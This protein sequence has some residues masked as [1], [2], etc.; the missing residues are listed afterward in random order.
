M[1]EESKKRWK[2]GLTVGIALY[3]LLFLFLIL[4]ANGKALSH[5]LG[6]VLMLFRPILLG[7]GLSY[8]CNPFFKF[9]ERKCFRHLRPV[10]LR[11]ALSL[12]LAYL[13]ILLFLAV[14][15]M[16]IL[17]NLAES[18]KIL[19]T[20]WDSYMQKATSVFNGLIEQVNKFMERFTGEPLLLKQI[21]PNEP[22]PEN[23]QTNGLLQ[24]LGELLV[25][26]DI[27]GVIEVISGA[28]SLLTDIIFAFFISIYLLGTK[29]KRYAQVM[30]LRYAL[31]NNTW[32][33]NITKFLTVV[34]EAFGSYLIGKL[35]ESFLMGL[36]L[37]C[38][39]SLFGIPYALLAAVFIAITNIIPIIGAYIGAVPTAFI[40]LLA[41]PLKVIPFVAVFLILQQINANIISPKILGERTGISALS[42]LIG[43]CIMGSVFGLAG[44][45][46]GVPLFAALLYM[47][48]DLLS[49]KL[50]QKGLPVGVANYYPAGSIVNPAVD[51]TVH[52]NRIVFS[53]EH[54]HLCVLQKQANAQPISRYQRT[55]DRIYR[56]ARRKNWIAELSDETATA[57][58][59]ECIRKDAAEHAEALFEERTSRATEK[60]DAQP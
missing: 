54:T 35:M 33:R 13:T 51:A 44:M 60:G 34:N 42:V 7:L 1:S 43:I 4:V 19:L 59:A 9:Y 57:F 22:I 26:I 56:F 27:N 41:E 47:L 28:V 11:R 30:K 12:A 48:E 20:N 3:A 2:K 49:G 53:L 39:I 46:L 52:R 21:S 24:R 55:L 17:P 29:E 38:F 10:G 50:Q 25:Q 58:S 36:L 18:F 16:L 15:L 45:I 14:L 8:I 40:I 37:Y 32:N 31:F 6:D 5:W 23:R